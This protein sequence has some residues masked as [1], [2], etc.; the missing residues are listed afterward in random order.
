MVGWDG[1]RLKIWLDDE[2]NP[3]DWV[4]NPKSWFWVKNSYDAIELLDDIRRKGNTV[5]VMSFDHD[6]GGSDTSR[7]VVLW[8]CEQEWWPKECRVHSANPVGYE[9]LSGMINRYGPG[10]SR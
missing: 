3:N 2:R 7:R 10:V 1:S 8:C 4:E 6:L 5:D 9:W